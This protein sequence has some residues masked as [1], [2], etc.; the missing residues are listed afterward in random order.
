MFAEAEKIPCVFVLLP[1]CVRGTLRSNDKEF[2]G[3][4]CRLDNFDYDSYFSANIR[5][6]NNHYALR[7]VRRVIA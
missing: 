4:A 5:G 3:R 1:D 6:V 7:G 2:L